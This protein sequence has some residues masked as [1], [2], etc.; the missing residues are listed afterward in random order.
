MQEILIGSNVTLEWQFNDKSGN[1]TACLNATIKIFDSND[2]QVGSSVVLT[3]DNEIGVGLY[4]YP[5]TIP[6]LRPFFDVE[7]SVTNLLGEKDSKRPRIYTKWSEE[8]ASIIPI[9]TL[10]V[11]TNT[12]ISLADADTYLASQFGTEKW[13]E[14]SINDKSR[15]L[16]TA[17]AKIDQLMLVGRMY[18]PFNGVAALSENTA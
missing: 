1:P 17:T 3:N 4:S 18:D 10:T 8:D 13:F 2:I 11:G 9:V 5:L 12:Y 6:N 16:I 7:I 14:S 15:A